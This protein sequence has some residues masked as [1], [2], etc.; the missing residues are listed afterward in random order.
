[1]PTFGSDRSRPERFVGLSI[2]PSE[3]DFKE[4]AISLLAEFRDVC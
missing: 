4:F 2:T 3:R 1:M